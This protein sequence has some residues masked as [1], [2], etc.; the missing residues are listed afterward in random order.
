MSVSLLV[1]RKGQLA[2]NN[3]LSHPLR[4]SSGYWNTLESPKITV[5]MENW[6]LFW[7]W[8]SNWIHKRRARKTS[9]RKP[10]LCGHRKGSVKLM[11]FYTQGKENV[12]PNGNGTHMAGSRQKKKIQALSKFCWCYPWICKRFSHRKHVFLAETSNL[13]PVNMQSCSCRSGERGKKESKFT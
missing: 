3:W 8:K 9:L 2:A 1:T 5:G 12:F 13:E 4:S 10:G 6:P 11:V 7:G